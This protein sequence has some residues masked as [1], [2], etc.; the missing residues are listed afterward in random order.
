MDIICSD[1]TILPNQSALQKMIANYDCPQQ[2]RIF[3]C[4]AVYDYVDSKA[5]SV[6]ADD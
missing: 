3:E 2:M 4:A 1:Q 6:I 5:L